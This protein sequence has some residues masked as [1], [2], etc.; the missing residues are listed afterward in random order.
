M[1]GNHPILTFL[2]LAMPLLNSLTLYTKLAL[3]LPSSCL[4]FARFTGLCYQA[5]PAFHLSLVPQMKVPA[6][7]DGGCGVGPETLLSA[8]EPMGHTV[9]PFHLPFP[10]L[11]LTLL[12]FLGV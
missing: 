11:V 9:R 5:Q 1:C 4:S 6:S 8:M 2:F 12:S 7:L 3:H 10:P